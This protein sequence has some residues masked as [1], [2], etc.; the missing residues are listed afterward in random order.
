MFIY[1][2]IYN[3]YYDSNYNNSFISPHKTV[4]ML[5]IN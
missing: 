2:H 1:I 4:A 5:Y 3:N